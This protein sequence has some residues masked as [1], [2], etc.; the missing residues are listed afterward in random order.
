MNRQLIE[1]A[2]WKIGC[3]IHRKHPHRMRIIETHPGGGMY[4][5]LSI[6][7]MDRP[8]VHVDLNRGGSL[9]IFGPREHHSNGEIWE[10][11]AEEKDP[12]NIVETICDKLELPQVTKLPASSSITL[13]YR[14]IA[15]FLTHAAFGI[16]AWECRSGY[17]DT[18]GYGGGYSKDFEDFPKAKERLMT[19]T[20][21]DYPGDPA[22]RF[23]FLRKNNRPVICLEIT[24]NAWIC[25]NESTYKLMKIY[26]KNNRGI[27]PTVVAVTGQ[28]MG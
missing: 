22:Y 3:E 25:E 9:H 6:C 12:K 13:T 23:W 10:D 28:V 27:W 7:D 15:T 24:G 14:F 16:N 4:D 18:S 26:K 5:C 17:C 21:Y 20:E 11:V 19:R 8:G 2:S 1:I